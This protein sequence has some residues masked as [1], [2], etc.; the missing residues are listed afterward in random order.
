MDDTLGGVDRVPGW[1]EDCVLTHADCWRPPNVGSRFSDFAQGGWKTPLPTRL[2][3]VGNKENDFMPFLY[4]PSPEEYGAYICLSYCWGNR[5]PI[6]TTTTTI[7]E[8]RKGIPW[9]SLGATFNNALKVAQVLRLEY[10][11]IDSLCILQDDEKDWEKESSMMAEI[12]GQSLFTIIAATSPDATSGFIKKN[13]RDYYDNYFKSWSISRNLFDGQTNE[14]F[15]RRDSHLTKFE[16]YIDQRSWAFQEY[17]LPTRLLIFDHSEVRWECN[18]TAKCC[19]SKNAQSGLKAM[20]APYFIAGAQNKSE[21]TRLSESWCQVVEFYT[22]RTI[23]YGSDKLVALSG[24]ARRF[25]ETFNGT[26]LAG[27]WVEDIYHQLAWEA[28]EGRVVNRS[29]EYRSPSWSW[30]SVDGWVEF[31]RI[32][33]INSGNLSRTGGKTMRNEFSVHRESFCEL[34][35]MDC[36]GAIY[37]GFIKVA[38]FLSKGKYKSVPT[39]GK[40]QHFCVRDLVE[41][42]FT[43]DFCRWV[44]ARNSIPRNGETLYLLKMAYILQVNQIWWL[45]AMVLRRS[46][47]TLG[48]FERIGMIHS[49]EK[50]LDWF[51][52]AELEGVIVV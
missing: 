43:P 6:T 29:S 16:R 34:S 37:G 26:Y 9:D 38:G 40:P 24:V 21:L 13:S 5:M 14:I 23:S 17:F 50:I 4:E 45:R 25:Q 41:Q 31:P 30:A 36:T 51:V 19:C 2:I 7:A 39:P 27:L 18:T 47:T 20:F 49:S 10:I 12:Y 8:R 46:P 3:H 52:D 48:A 35:S 28:K 22:R 1:M 11:W 33:H 42:E 32:I 44:S 15:A